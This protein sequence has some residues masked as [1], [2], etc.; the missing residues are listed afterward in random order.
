MSYSLNSL[1]GI[2]G[3]CRGLVSG[4]LKGIVGV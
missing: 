4:L 3:D 2:I 1:K